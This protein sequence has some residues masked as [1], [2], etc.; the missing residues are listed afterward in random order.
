MLFER[1]RK[2]T[3]EYI[4]DF[5]HIRKG[6]STIYALGKCLRVVKD[7]IL[8]NGKDLKQVNGFTINI[9]IYENNR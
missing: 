3:Q 6:T 8:K 7:N 9:Q 4:P 1:L 5:V 2:M